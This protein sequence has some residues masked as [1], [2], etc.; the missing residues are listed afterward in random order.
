M[1]RILQFNLVM[2]VLLLGSVALAQERTISGKVTSAEDGSA[3]PGVNVVLKGTSIGTATDATGT[4]SLSVPGSGGTLIFSFI[5]LQ[6]QEI[7]IGDRT[8][9]DIALS[10]DATQLNE[11]VVVGY[12]VQESR[13]ITSSISSISGDALA[14]LAT[15]SFDQQLGGRAAGVQLV[16]PS[17]LLGANPIIRVRGVNSISSGVDPLIVIDNV[18]MISGNQSFLVNVST[19]PL[20]DINPADIES[21]EI[22][23]DG[24]A[25][26][27]YGSRAANGVI[28]ITT[29]RG[30]NKE[31]LKVNFSATT[32]YSETATRFDLLNASEFELIANEKLTNAGIATA[33]FSDPANPVDT[34]WQD[35]IFRSGGFS[36]FNLNLAG[37]SEKTTYFF[38]GG[39][40][41]QEGAAVNSNFDRFSFRSNIDHKLNKFIEIGLNASVSRSSTSGL[42]SGINALSGNITAGAVLL[43]N[44]PVYDAA[45]PTGYNLSSGNTAL[46]PW[47]NTRSI[48]NNYTNLKFVLDNNKIMAS[49]SRI[50]ANGYLKFNIVEGLSA[51]TQYAIDYLANRDFQSLDPRHG[52]GRGSGGSITTAHRD[53]IRWNWQNLLTYR[54]DFGEHSVDATGGVE[55]QLTTNNRIT[56]GGTAFSDL[57]FQQVNLITGTYATQTSSGFYQQNGYDSYFGRINYSY[58]NKYLVGLSARNDA[59]SDLAPEFRR[60]TFFG[61]S[62]GYVVSEEDFFLNSSLARIFNNLKVRGSYAEVGNVDI[63]AFAYAGLYGAARYGSQNGIGFSQAGND[64]LL[65]ETSKKFNVGLDFG[66]LSNRI[67]FTTDYFKN[68]VDGIILFAPTPY[69][70]GIPYSFSLFGTGINRNIGALTNSGIEFSVGADVM[71]KGNFRW[72]VNANFTSLKNEITALVKNTAGVDQDQL[73]NVSNVLTGSSILRVGEP[74]GSFFGY[75]YAGV[76]PANGNPM[77]V[78]GDGRIVQRRV[79]TG[80]YSFFDPNNP[81]DVSNTSGAALVFA[82]V[83]NGGD[84]RV[85][86]NPL[87]KWYGGMS[88]QFSYKNFDL[89]IFLRFSGGNQIY[90]AT[91][92]STLYN[93]DFLNGGKG[94]LNRWTPENPNTNVPKL[95]LN[96]NQQVNQSNTVISRF[97]ED[98]DFL[99]I[100]NIV[101]GYNVPRSVL[102]KTGNLGIRSVKFFVQAQ[103]VFTFTKYSGLDP[104]LNVSN[105]PRITG[106]DLNS[107]P[108]L[109]T[110]TGGV[111]IGF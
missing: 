3:L 29:K 35:V 33:A 107:N 106:I 6:S 55:Y 32:G 67:R 78:K 77:Y 102:D 66:I 90:N 88:N 56:A 83:A 12:G 79:D 2:L 69:S 13:K 74:I 24:A 95:Y 9:F 75:Q 98:G 48:D 14:N 92:Q 8:T 26:A 41:Y 43:P 34:D 7:A 46:G 45:N 60:G 23:K 37:G 49:T 5:G 44:V 4:Y 82:D 104:E 76:N 108:Q 15:P 38:S 11:V 105:D 73:L 10:L 68:D 39:Y 70:V 36:N 81:T 94:L 57:F 84:A 64:Q 110:I 53:L 101:L 47:F 72:S 28:L 96:R 91:A 65:W 99:K 22:L 51:R 27:I 42:N 18:P 62:L 61:G 20:A 52:D 50:L 111:N 30:S 1:K 17:G 103:N 63:P 58:K 109:R 71:T 80:A 86:G 85:L 19:N 21:I 93:T 89:E 87:P 16:I 25:T 40:Q 59:T 31:K 54:K 100:Q 97:I